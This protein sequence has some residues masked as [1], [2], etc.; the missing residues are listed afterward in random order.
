MSHDH[1]FEGQLRIRAKSV[2]YFDGA[3]AIGIGALG[4]RDY[5]KCLLVTFDD[6]VNPVSC[7]D[8]SRWQVKHDNVIS[9]PVSVSMMGERQVLLELPSLQA[10]Q[11]YTLVYRVMDLNNNEQKGSIEFPGI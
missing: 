3:L 4:M 7:D 10:G 2:V 1:F 6:S 5:D 8:R 11:S 9:I